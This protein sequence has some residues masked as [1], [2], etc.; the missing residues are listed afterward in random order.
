MYAAKTHII[1]NHVVIIIIKI[2]ALSISIDVF[3]ERNDDCDKGESKPLLRHLAT[4]NNI[5]SHHHY[6][7]FIV[8]VL[9]DSDQNSM[10]EDQQR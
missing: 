1:M 8:C 5:A 7:F 9:D 2:F 6:F 3:Q 10:C 4:A